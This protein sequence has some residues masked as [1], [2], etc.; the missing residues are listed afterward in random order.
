MELIV[1]FFKIIFKGI[2]EGV[3]SI[4]TKKNKKTRFFEIGEFEKAAKY[5][6][7]QS[8]GDDVYFS[9]AALQPGIEEGRGKVSDVIALRCLWADIDIG[10]VNHKSQKYPE[11]QK[12]ALEILEKFKFKPS[13]IIESGYGLHVYFL[14]KKP[15][16]IN[17]EKDRELLKKISKRFQLYLRAHYKKSGYDIDDTSDLARVL[18]VPDTKNFKSKPIKAVKIIKKDINASYLFEDIQAVVDSGVEKI[19]DVGVKRANASETFFISPESETDSE[20]K[21]LVEAMLHKKG[22]SWM[23]H[24]RNDADTLSEKEWFYMLVIMS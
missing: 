18:R 11:T 1:K 13:F 22:C 21:P 24:C 19:V 16:V 3:F 12:K 9:V 15:F 10:T 20:K 5:A 6:I 17:N 23:R 2:S 8:E 7:K 14:F 4:W